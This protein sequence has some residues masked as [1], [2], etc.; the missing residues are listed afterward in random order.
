M[1]GMSAQS[2]LEDCLSARLPGCM[3]ALCMTCHATHVAPRHAMLPISMPCTSFN[4]HAMHP[5]ATQSTCHAMPCT[6]FDIHAIPCHPHATPCRPCHAM[7]TPCHAMPPHACPPRL[8]L[9]HCWQNM[10]QHLVMIT[11]FCRWW[12]TLQLIMA[13]SALHSAC[14]SVR[15]AQWQQGA[16]VRRHGEQCRNGMNM[17]STTM[18]AAAAVAWTLEPL[19]QHSSHTCSSVSTA[20][21]VAFCW[22]S[23]SSRCWASCGAETRLEKRLALAC[24]RTDERCP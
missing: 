21:G 12:H 19:P 23:R 17:R 7:P 6:S 5:H 2:Q 22:R 15:N 18:A 4:I 14:E 3:P 24:P 16:G 10:C 1:S 11:S 20:P 13:R 9:M 8:R